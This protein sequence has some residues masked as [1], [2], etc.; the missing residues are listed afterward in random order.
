MH[1][2][3][4]IGYL[5]ADLGEVKTTFWYTWF[6]YCEDLKTQGF[7]NEFNAII[8]YLREEGN[9]LHSLPDLTEY[10]RKHPEA[11]LKLEY[12][13][14]SYGFKINTEEYSYYIRGLLTPKDYN[15]YCYCYLRDSQK[16]KDMVYHSGVLTLMS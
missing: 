14:D 5:R 10:C 12:R 6:G 16:L 2:R 3:G 7:I 9:M 8:D 11:H 4:C 15:V 13:D 1:R